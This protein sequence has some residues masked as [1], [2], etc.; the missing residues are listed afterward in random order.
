MA[1]TSCVL[2]LDQGFTGT[3]W[4]THFRTSFLKIDISEHVRNSTGSKFHN[5]AP[6]YK[7]PDLDIVKFLLICIL[8]WCLCG[9]IMS[10]HGVLNLRY[11]DRYFGCPLWIILK[12]WRSVWKA[13][14]WCTER[15]W[16]DFRSSTVGVFRSWFWHFSLSTRFWRTCNLLRSSVV[17]A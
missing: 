5:W 11:P 13:L 14:N 17:K 2:T 4:I 15:S 9:K 16:Q 6:L 1:S 10:S 7:K 12:T 3:V 8:F